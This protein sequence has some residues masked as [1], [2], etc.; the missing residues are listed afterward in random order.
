MDILDILI[1]LIFTAAF[2]LNLISII[3]RI[4]SK[5]AKGERAF[6][7]IFRRRFIRIPRTLYFY[8]K[9]NPRY[10]EETFIDT[11]MS[12][13]VEITKKENSRYQSKKEQRLINRMNDNQK[14]QGSIKKISDNSDNEKEI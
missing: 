2:I 11:D 3:L 1:Y 13:D 14:G 7:G 9:D 10:S 6:Q 8:M 12:D 5:K 4:K